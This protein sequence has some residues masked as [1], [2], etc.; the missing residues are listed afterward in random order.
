MTYELP[1]WRERH[2]AILSE[3]ETK[4]IVEAW[5]SRR[6]I[7]PVNR[8]AF[9]DFSKYWRDEKVTTRHFVPLTDDE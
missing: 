6:L 5:R 8:P 9:G 7:E 2:E 1:N 4:E 3:A